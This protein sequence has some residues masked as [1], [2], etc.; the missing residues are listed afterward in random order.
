MSKICSKCHTLKDEEKFRKGHGRICREC[1]KLYYNQHYAE[2][3]RKRNDGS[4][5]EAPLHRRYSS[6][7]LD[8]MSSKRGE[9][10]ILGDSKLESGERQLKQ[11]V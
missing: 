10:N 7:E 1:K 5:T 3:G 2:K 4:V 11:I 8:K 9:E 6:Y